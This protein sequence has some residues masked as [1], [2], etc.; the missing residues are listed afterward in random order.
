[1]RRFDSSYADRDYEIRSRHGKPWQLI[2]DENLATLFRGGSDPP[3]MCATMQRPAS[4]IL[5]RLCKLRLLRLHGTDHWT[6]YYAEVPIMNDEALIRPV[7]SPI[8][9]KDTTMSTPTIETRILIQGR[10]AAAMSDAQIFDLIGEI[11]GKITKL[12]AIKAQPKKLVAAIEAL[13]A[14]I[15]KLVEYVDIRE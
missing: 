7:K 13:K 9:C 2:E 4:G 10:N 12:E 11:E 14:D 8:V 5:S 15:A 6:Y 3:L 1:M